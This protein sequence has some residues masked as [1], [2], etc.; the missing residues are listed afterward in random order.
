MT[1]PGGDDKDKRR[2]GGDDR[3]DN[4]SRRSG[5]NRDHHT[6]NRPGGG[7]PKGTP[8]SGGLLLSGAPLTEDQ[9]MMELPKKKFTG[10]CRLFVGNLTNDTTEVELKEMF[11]PHGDI[12]ECYISGKGFA[13]LRMDTRAHAES[14]KETID[15]KTLHGRPVRVRFAV[16]GAAL[17]IKELPTSVSN[18]MLYHAF[19]AF[20]EVE[21]AV[22]IVDEK[23]KPTGEGI[24]E[25]ERKPSAQEALNQIR[26]RVFLMTANSRPLTVEPLEPRDEDDGLA[27]RMI[28]RSP[29]LMKEREI[30]PRFPPSNSFEY[31][32][33]K[34]WKELY[35][36]ERKKREELEAELSEARR[37]L[38]L[39]MEVAYQDY[40]AQM[41]REDLQRR[42]QE[43]ERLE[44]QRRMRAQNGSRG[45][46]SFPGFGGIDRSGPPMQGGPGVPPP[47]P[48]QGMPGGPN[49]NYLDSLHHTK[50][51]KN[52]V[53]NRQFQ[54][55]PNPG[56]FPPGPSVPGRGP[57]PP[58]LMGGPGPAFQ[59][60]FQ[61]GPPPQGDFRP[62][63]KRM[64]QPGMSLYGIFG[65]GASDP[66]PPPVV[67]A[68]LPE[69]TPIAPESK[70]ESAQK[71][72]LPSGMNLQFLQ[73][74]I[75]LKKAQMAQQ[76]KIPKVTP[77]IGNSNQKTGFKLKPRKAV[78]LP[79]SEGLSL[80]FIPKAMVEDKVF[81]FGEIN[82]EDE[83][84]PTTPSDFAIA[85]MKR[86]EQRAKQKMAREIADRARR[87]HEEE[88]A[89]RRKGAAIAPPTAL[90]E[91][92]TPQ[93]EVPQDA[94]TS[95]STAASLM[96]PPSFTPSFGSG[97]K[98]LGV[99]A[100][101]MSRMGY[102][103][104]SGLGKDEQGM[105]TA[106]QVEKVGKNVGFIKSEKKEAPPPT[107]CEVGP[108]NMVMIKSATKILLLRNMVSKEE[109]DS[110]LEPEIRGEMEKY[111]QVTKVIIHPEPEEEVRIFVEF[112]NVAQAIKAFI[113]LNGRFFGGRSIRAGFYPV[114]VYELKN[115]DRIIPV[116]P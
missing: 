27:E 3:R 105:S 110:D 34:K 61:G 37:R 65:E 48:P 73:S 95:S 35:E 78:P 81:L 13:F 53:P 54:Q 94:P 96:P 58:P 45:P 111:G 93:A 109:V 71:S 16:H 104:G 43:L 82:I 47:G 5:N 57:M 85:K 90:L 6:G 20:G 50:M 88:E 30:G 68:K 44:E 19:S 12:S 114:D 55:Q 63:E 7:G 1:V 86:D 32:Y 102:K 97:S 23:G 76:A 51:F 80:S 84:D 66:P 87:E 67:T 108:S 36:M 74:Q 79:A 10:R 29:A 98:G 92:T 77:K 89:K 24:V 91:D 106:L 33:G 99:A 59:M 8:G 107:S 2:G 49:G 46:S 115:Y 69:V 17:K 38:E 83:Y 103:E 21:R 14:A 11:A 116:P 31:I 100:S 101:I 9:L 62:P 113:D 26:E 56:F 60:P 18:E 4:R 15:G 25:F 41:L 22:H 112:T 28:P 42:Q 75:R 39:D 72:N 70:K 40:Q 52:D 64:R